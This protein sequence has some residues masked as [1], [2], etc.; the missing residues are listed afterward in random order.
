MPL[1]VALGI[2]IQICEA[3]HHAHERRDKAG[4]PLR[5]VHRDVTPQNVMITRDGVAKMLDFGIART[6]AR[7]ETDAGVV[8][9]TFAY[10]APEQVRA[11]PLDKRADVFALGVI[12]Y[13]VTTGTRLFRGTDVQVMTQV[14]EQ[15]V[16]PPSARAPGYPPE[17]EDIVLNA[18]QRDRAMRT[19]SA[20]HLAMSLEEYATR[21]GMLV[22]PR[23]VARYVGQVFPYER[24]ADAS[25]AI[26]E[27]VPHLELVAE[28]PEGIDLLAPA[29]AP[30]LYGDDPYAAARAASAPA[31]RSPSALEALGD[32]SLFDDLALLAQPPPEPAPV[33]RYDPLTLPPE[34]LSDGGDFEAVL[35]ESLPPAAF[36]SLP[37][38]DPARDVPRPPRAPSRF[39]PAPRGS[40]PTLP[41]DALDVEDD[42][43]DRPVLLLAPQRPPTGRP[44]AEPRPP[45]AGTPAEPRPSAQAP[46]YMSD[47]S[48]RIEGDE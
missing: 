29:F 22:G 30:H 15:D 46:D 18:L 36:D 13:E 44:A 6:A 48:R 14:V 41:P 9:G 26:V 31:P 16:T 4:R 39:G 34:A 28:P 45:G 43:G 42:D 33:D 40:F 8:R 5:I 12:L 32:E 27:D 19:P 38:V 47:L 24:L 23:T 10:M 21:N 11:R 7:K 1:P 35:L 37:G 2:V 20:S 3:L 17:L 25:S